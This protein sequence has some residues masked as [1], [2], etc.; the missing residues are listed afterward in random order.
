MVDGKTQ[1]E[2]RDGA[3]YKD[4]DKRVRAIYITSIL[5]F[6]YLKLLLHSYISQRSPSS[7][8]CN[9]RDWSILLRA[10]SLTHRQVATVISTTG[11]F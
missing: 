10:D 6:H 5:N 9:L 8:D 11:V 2:L 1:S 3:I 4:K 7:G